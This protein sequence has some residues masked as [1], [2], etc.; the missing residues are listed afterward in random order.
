MI[1]RSVRE[2]VCGCVCI[3][4]NS[5][6]ESSSSS[7]AVTMWFL[8]FFTDSRPSPFSAC[9]SNA[10]SCTEV[11]RLFTRK[12][13]VPEVNVIGWFGGALLRFEMRREH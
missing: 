2:S 12:L 9:S 1:D 11:V 6:A 3:R 5:I 7:A 10:F 4:M 13:K 8:V